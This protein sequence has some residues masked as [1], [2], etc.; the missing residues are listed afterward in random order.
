M[1]PS[2]EGH[3]NA[4]RGHHQKPAAK[5]A[6]LPKLI[7]A[8]DTVLWSTLNRQ[9]AIQRIRKSPYLST[10]LSDPERAR[11]VV[12]ALACTRSS[13]RIFRLLNIIHEL[14]Y[15]LKQN[16]YQA[17]TY[18][19][20]MRKLWHAVLYVVT[21]GKRHT[22][23]TT[24]RLLNWRA[25]GLAEIQNYALLPRVL[26]EFKQ[27]NITPTRRT[28]HLILSGHIRNRNLSMAK[29][30]L[31]S[32]EEA[33]FS[34]DASTHA[35]V[36]T[37]YRSL[38]ADLQ[39]QTRALEALPGIRSTTAASVV[40]SLIQLRIDVHD[41]PGA[42][43][44]LSLFNHQYVAIV[45][46]VM[47]VGD[48][49]VTEK[50]TLEFPDA[51]ASIRGT[52]IPNAATFSV[53]INYLATQSNL[54]GALQ[55]LRS[56]T[57]TNV[58][59]TPGL[60]SSVLHVLFSG[61]RGDI[62]VRLVAGMCDPKYVPLTLF[63]P[64]L[65]SSYNV[66]EPLPWVP[67]GIS[68]TTRVLNALLKGVLNT[69]GLN[70]ASVVLR[71]MRAINLQPNAA[72]LDI[73][74]AHLGQV[75]RTEPSLVL[76]LLRNLL[77]T[78]LRPSLRHLHVILSCMLRH[79]KYLLYGRGWDS[80]AALFS[81]RRQN[82]QR[83]YP[84]KRISGVADSFDPL[85][86]MDL[87]RGLSPRPIVQSIVQSLSSRRIMS[88]MVTVGLRIRHDA[89][90]KSDTESARNI[91]NLLLSR[92]MYPNEYHFSALMEGFAQSGDME[93]AVNVMRSARQVGVTPNV[94]MF[95]IL[96]VG[97]GRQGNPDIAM[98]V[99]EEMVSSGIK[100]DVPAIDA[101]SGAFFAVG[102]YAMAKKV[103]ISLWPHI[104]PF[105]KE[106][107]G[108]SL[109]TLACKFRLLHKL[110]DDWKASAKQERILLLW[111]LKR[112][113]TA[114]ARLGIERKTG[115]KRPHSTQR[116]KVLQKNRTR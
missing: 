56:M 89:L 88:D 8:V 71:I 52:L 42:M 28:Y 13:R 6:E 95:T 76:Q 116:G 63:K 49:G 23:R 33:G 82:S 58:S 68:P 114:W 99:F 36:A 37:H 80:T 3:R 21:L 105:P 30:C 97:H 64:L 4:Y 9:C 66:A 65:S 84:E 77:S 74:V 79:E 24:S 10:A 45:F 11:Q 53:F 46:D 51:V 34:I 67:S 87:P 103:L 44:L 94:V 78:T 98:R 86:G 48:G 115:L 75:K 70:G 32:M 39:V 101:V 14:G 106:L 72:T 47:S 112:L 96:I 43:Q 55:I 16:T 73:I 93:A 60:V 102:A 31:R 81:P 29:Q 18:Q 69:I 54:S 38:G 20:A 111:K 62:A 100:P 85:A 5:E 113:R 50:G 109:K 19:F 91:F 40:N 107:R 41:I 2:G 22:G 61:G 108:T 104:Q 17:V 26:D 15:R 1:H 7:A 35:I 25:R 12:E 59:P 92:G 83:P 90:L 57:I 27:N 110:G